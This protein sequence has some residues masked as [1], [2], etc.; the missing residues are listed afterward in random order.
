[1]TD[2]GASPESRDGLFGVFAM[3]TF[4]NLLLFSNPSLAAQLHQ[5]P[6]RYYPLTRLLLLTFTLSASLIGVN[7]GAAPFATT[8]TSTIGTV[9][10]N[11][12]F[13][14]LKVGETFQITLVMDNGGAVATHQTEANT[15]LVR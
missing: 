15:E 11:T 12:T 9:V 8:Y 6:N 3:S 2:G 5:P 14:E 4:I 7:A 1:M 13:P 10:N